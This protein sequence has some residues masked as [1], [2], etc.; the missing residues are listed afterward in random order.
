MDRHQGRYLFAHEWWSDVYLRWLQSWIVAVLLL[1][2]SLYAQDSV[3]LG[4]V[5]YAAGD[6]AMCD[7]EL[8]RDEAT[9]RLI[10]RDTGEYKVAALGDLAY[11]TGQPEEWKC[12]ND[13]WGQFKDKTIPSDGNHEYYAGSINRYY[14]Y[15]NGVGNDSGPAG[16]RGR[17]NHFQ[18]YGKWLLIS[19]SSE[20][21]VGT[22]TDGQRHTAGMKVQSA[23][24]G[25]VMRQNPAQCQMLLTHRTLFSSS[26]GGEQKFM[27]PA[28]DTFYT[29]KGDV[30]ASGH[31]HMKGLTRII[32]SEGNRVPGF[33]QFILG[34]GG[35]LE[36]NPL[37]TMKSYMLWR[38]TMPGIPGVGKFILEDSL[39]R[40]QILDTLGTVMHEGQTLCR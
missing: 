29:Y 11:E 21:M 27:Q 24:L 6:V 10:M 12:Y 15:F 7:P 18:R 13:S 34:G 37:D 33:R 16:K 5:L 2:P 28:Y 4:K 36:A 39:Y 1:T 9:A 38:D 19:L 31:V 26:I 40:W 32:D 22:G 17:G 23:W 14:D 8:A 35:K 3:P 20:Y 25:K 30:V